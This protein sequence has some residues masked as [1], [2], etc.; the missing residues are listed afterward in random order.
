M[1]RKQTEVT[2]V[3]FVPKRTSIGNGKV[4]MSSMN[5]HKRRSYKKYNKQGK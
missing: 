3:N 4:K 2:N 5:K 1:P